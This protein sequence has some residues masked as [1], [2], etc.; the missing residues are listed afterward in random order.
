MTLTKLKKTEQILL[1]VVL[2]TLVLGIYSYFRFIPKNDAISLA[3]RQTAKIENK[4]YRA[5]VPNEPQ[6]NVEELLAELDEQEQLLALTQEM[7]ANIEQRLAP[8]GSQQLKVAISELARNS[9]VQ[10]R[11]NETYHPPKKL[12][13]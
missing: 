11:T 4:L 3:Q 13:L 1:A 6:Q 7:S 5:K 10:I 12:A 9:G 2:T 8:V